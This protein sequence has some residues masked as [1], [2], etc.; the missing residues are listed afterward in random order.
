M[1]EAERAVKGRL[2]PPRVDE[3]QW[4]GEE[5]GRNEKQAWGELA[6]GRAGRQAGGKSRQW[7]TKHRKQSRLIK[8]A[9]L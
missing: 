2:R 3:G 4:G 1:E 9:C 6:E 7:R 5:A 8:T